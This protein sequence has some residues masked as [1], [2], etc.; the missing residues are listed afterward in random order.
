MREELKK[1]QRRLQITI[2]FV[3]HDQ[4]EAMM[5]STRIAVMKKGEIVQ[6]GTPQRNL[7]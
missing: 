2:I 3:T 6:V 4:E 5:L 7:Q 1:I